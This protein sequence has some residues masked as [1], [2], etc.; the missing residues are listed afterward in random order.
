MENFN[1]YSV[2]LKEAV[3]GLAIKPDGIYVDCTAGGGGHSLEIVK[4]LTDGG[5]LYAIDQDVEAIAA[6][7]KRLGDYLDRVTFIHDNFV[8][9]KQALAEL[10]VIA[11]VILSVV[12]ILV[13]VLLAVVIIESKP[14]GRLNVV[15][16]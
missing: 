11:L 4:R 10:E 3:D 5:H 1:H 12:V 13:S 8:N 7:T 6:A 2:M 16:A 14:K 9:V 15:K